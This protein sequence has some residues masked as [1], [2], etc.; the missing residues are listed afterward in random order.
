MFKFL[1]SSFVASSIADNFVP[2]AEGRDLDPDAQLQIEVTVAPTDGCVQASSGDQVSV[3]YTGWAMRDATKFDSSVE[4]GQPL[5]FRLGAGMV[6]A[7][8][9]EGVEGMCEGEK[10]ILTIPSGKAY[11]ER[12]AGGVIK[13]NATLIFEVELMK[14]TKKEAKKVKKAKKSDL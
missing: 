7:G 5:S 2:K 3:H 6:I 11:K 12:G 1:L 4:R 8:W 9:D 14:I 13:P 10:R